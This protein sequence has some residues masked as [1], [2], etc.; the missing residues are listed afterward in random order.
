MNTLGIDKMQSSNLFVQVS[1]S[2]LLNVKIKAELDLNI[3]VA[4]MILSLNI[5]LFS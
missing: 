2:A 1:S 4:N 5:L 3:F